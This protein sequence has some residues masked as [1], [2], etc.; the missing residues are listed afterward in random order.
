MDFSILT[1][2]KYSQKGR[3]NNNSISSRQEAYKKD[4]KK[5]NIRFKK[6]SFPK[7]LLIW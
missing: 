6:I 1:D 3:K 5:I 2:N 4:T 7:F